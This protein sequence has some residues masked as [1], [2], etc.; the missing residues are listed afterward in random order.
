[1]HVCLYEG[2]GFPKTVVT[3]SSEQPC[4]CKE[5]NVGP[6]EEQ[7][8]FSTTESFLFPSTKL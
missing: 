8:M 1:M 5:F 2:S 7:S 3:D 4:G 6:L